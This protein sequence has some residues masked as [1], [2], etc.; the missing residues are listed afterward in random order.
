M[1][2]KP[3]QFPRQESP[4]ALRMQV[5][6]RFASGPTFAF[7]LA[8]ELTQAASGGAG[9]EGTEA[10]SPAAAPILVLF[11]AS[12]SGKTTALR[13]LAGLEKPDSG[14]IEWREQCWVDVSRRIFMPPQNRQIGLVFQ[15]YALFPHLSVEGNLRF[16]MPPGP[17]SE[18]SAK[19]QAMLARVGLEGLAARRPSEL[20]GGQKQRVAL[21][22]ALLR[23]PQLLLL[24]EPLS[25]LD[26]NTREQLRLELRQHIKQSGIPAIVVTHDRAEALALGDLMAV[27]EEGA[28]QQLGPVPEVFSH[29]R[30]LQVARAVGME[31]VL[32]G[33][34]LRHLEGLATVALGTV[35]ETGGALLIPAMSMP[36]AHTL[37]AFHAGLLHQDVYVCIRG[38]DVV[39]EP[40][41]V[42]ASSARNHLPVWVEGLQSE[43]A[44]VRVLL[45]WLPPEPSPI[46][47]SPESL[48]LLPQLVALITR[49]SCE[50]LGLMIGQ[51]VQ[52]S[53]KA[54]AIRLIP[55]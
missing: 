22:R 37:S 7:E 23:E 16:G 13:L 20:S 11:G 52:A 46:L 9:A 41:H 3:S 6:K 53:V 18:G 35:P 28:V 49:R 12:G 17:R 42:G 50:E 32:P 27:L 29:P 45:R 54:T 14:R 31:T 36:Q 39:V 8:L 38:E 5:E 33:R 10:Q 43:G 21:A 44:L 19:I 51:K 48:R 24:D 2:L 26:A 34:V 25:A 30:T 55:R 1:S 40:G 4:G 15:D 47:A